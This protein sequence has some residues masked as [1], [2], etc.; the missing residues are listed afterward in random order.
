[1][2]DFARAKS[3]SLARLKVSTDISLLKKELESTEKS[4]PECAA[5]SLYRTNKI[6][7]LKHR[8]N[9]L[10]QNLVSVYNTDH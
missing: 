6:S 2:E 5:E 7:I 10:E 9:E 1:M 3:D 8:I 4:M